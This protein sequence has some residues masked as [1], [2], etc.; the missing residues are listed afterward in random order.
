MTDDSLRGKLCSDVSSQKEV[1]SL[2]YDEVFR[3]YIWLLEEERK[4]I[5]VIFDFASALS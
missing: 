1:H 4:D 2:I 5:R 3:E